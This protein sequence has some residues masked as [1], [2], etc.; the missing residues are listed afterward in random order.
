MKRN[1]ISRLEE[2]EAKANV[3]GPTLIRIG[4]VSRLPADYVGEKHV[5]V[6]NCPIIP[7][8]PDVQWFTSREYPGPA[9]AVESIEP[10]AEGRPSSDAGV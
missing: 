8:R 2:L 10:S 9:P 4:W 1:L 3:D 6:K 7:G 5:V